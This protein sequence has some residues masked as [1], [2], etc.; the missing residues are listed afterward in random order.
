MDKKLKSKQELRRAIR[1]EGYIAVLDVLRC[2]TTMRVV[3]VPPNQ[4]IVMVSVNHV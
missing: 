3:S 1:K 4:M 2:Q